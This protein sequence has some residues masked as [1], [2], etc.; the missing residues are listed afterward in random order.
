MPRG[1]IGS[2][3]EHLDTIAF[4]LKKI[5][6]EAT[7]TAVMQQSVAKETIVEAEQAQKEAK[8]VKALLE[9]YEKAKG[10]KIPFSGKKKDEQIIVL[11]TK[12]EQ[13]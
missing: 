5:K 13:L 10:E 7:T 2:K 12:N 11:L 3:A 9:D 8:L 4:K 1:K 6:E